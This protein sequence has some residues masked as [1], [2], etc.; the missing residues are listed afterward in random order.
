[1]AE[2]IFEKNVF[3][4]YFFSLAHVP[5]TNREEAG[6]VTFTLRN[7]SYRTSFYI[8]STVEHNEKRPQIANHLMQ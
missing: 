8:K 1:M 3:Q 6:F 2:T 5:S 4:V 7:P